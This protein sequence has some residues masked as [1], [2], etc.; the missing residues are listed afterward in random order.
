MWADV[1]ARS[2]RAS[3]MRKGMC[4]NAYGYGLL[5]ANLACMGGLRKWVISGARFG[6][7][8]AAPSAAY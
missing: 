3:G 2:M 1:I 4:H 7:H 5:Q 8:D 6:R